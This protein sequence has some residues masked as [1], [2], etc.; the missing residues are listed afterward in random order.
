MIDFFIGRS[1]TR[2][3]NAEDNPLPIQRTIRE[4]LKI[5]RNAQLDRRKRSSDR[6]GRVDYDFIV[7]LSHSRDHRIAPDRRQ[8]QEFIAL[9]SRLHNKRKNHVDRRNSVKEGVFVK[10][11]SKND[12][13]SYIDRRGNKHL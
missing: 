6:R 13:R 7:N 3:W 10:L 9:N 11:T 1:P 5:T 2:N 4:P 12:R 8:N